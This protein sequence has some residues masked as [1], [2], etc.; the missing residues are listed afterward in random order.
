LDS[1]LEQSFKDFELIISDNASTDKTPEICREYAA[2][3]QRIRYFRQPKNLGQQRNFNFLLQQAQG[4]YFMWAA[5]D[6]SWGSEFIEILV[7]ALT[8]NDKSTSAFCPFVYVDEYNHPLSSPQVF[9]YSGGTVL[10]RIVKFC[11]YYNDAFFYGLHRRR[12]IQDVR[13]P[14]WRWIN[15][16]TPVNCAY[17]VLIFFLARGRYVQADTRPL[18]FNRIYVNKPPRHIIVF[19]RGKIVSYILNYLISGLRQANVFCE[20]VIAVYQGTRSISV[21]LVITPILAFRCLFNCIQETYFFLY[22]SLRFVIRGSKKII[23]RG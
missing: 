16:K 2:K 8:L 10:Q 1:L 15:S 12:L 17:P 23:I 6:D 5:S 9:D 13:V 21:C 20:S 22:Y 18:W 19:K 14:I 11:F 4:E 3:D 7:N